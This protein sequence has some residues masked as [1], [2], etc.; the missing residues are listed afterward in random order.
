MMF[1]TNIS[2]EI[3][4]R[5]V[6]ANKCYYGLKQQ[7]RSHHFT[8]RTK[9]GLYKALLRPVWIYGSEAWTVTKNVFRFFKG[10]SQVKCAQNVRKE[11]GEC[12]TVMK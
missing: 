2:K 10:K 5:T 1:N 3:K 9:C 8:L 4:D 12:Y 6:V 7:F 11:A